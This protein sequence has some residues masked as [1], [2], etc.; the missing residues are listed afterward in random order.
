M[1]RCGTEGDMCAAAQCRIAHPPDSRFYHGLLLQR[2]LLG[3][4]DDA[5]VA[6]DSGLQGQT[7]TSVA[8][9]CGLWTNGRRARMGMT[10]V[11]AGNNT[12]MR[13]CSVK[14]YVG[15]PVVSL[16]PLRTRGT[17]SVDSLGSIMT[18]CPLF[19]LPSLS[20]CSTI[21][22]LAIRVRRVHRGLAAQ[23]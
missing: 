5:S 6:Q 4:T 19:I 13:S 22:L 10:R 8:G 12:R 23:G 20:A 17:P 3:K 2:H 11:S 1:A 21:R 7:D 14:R 18:L 15:L 9:C 16:P